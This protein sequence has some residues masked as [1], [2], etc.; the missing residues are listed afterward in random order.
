MRKYRAR[1]AVAVLALPLL[2]L[3]GVAKV[4]VKEH[5]EF[6]PGPFDPRFPN[7]NEPGTCRKCQQL[8][9]VYYAAVALNDAIRAFSPRY[10]DTRKPA[11]TPAAPEPD[12]RQLAM[13]ESEAA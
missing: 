6:I 12:P 9:R 8:S 7:A 10:D 3:F 5:P 4:F 2:A 13:F 1:W 11:A